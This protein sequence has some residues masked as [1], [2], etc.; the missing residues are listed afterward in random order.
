MEDENP[1]R[2]QRDDWVNAAYAAFVQ[3]G[4]SAVKADPLAKS[5]GVTR[6]SF[7]WHFKN[8]SELMQ[9]VLNKWKTDQTDAVIAANERE[10]G[11]AAARLLRL[12]KFCA[13]DDGA[14]EM[15]IRNLMQTQPGIEAIVASIDETR[16]DYMAD[17]MVEMGKSQETAAKLSPVIYAAWLGEYS[18]AVQRSADHRM[19]NAEI[20]FDFI[21][22][23]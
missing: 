14:F 13:A 18:G 21:V 7:Y 19:A 9:A 12:L 4:V 22:K 5:L 8:V 17:L 1:N 10:G 16:I 3:A 20:L 15:G 11:A 6:G 2:L 23:P